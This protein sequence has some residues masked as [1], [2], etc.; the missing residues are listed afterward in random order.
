MGL[1]RDLSGIVFG[2][3]FIVEKKISADIYRPGGKQFAAEVQAKFRIP[4][5]AQLSLNDLFIKAVI[6]PEFRDSIAVR[7]IVCLCAQICFLK[8]RMRGFGKPDPFFSQ[9]HALKTTFPQWDFADYS[10]A[11]SR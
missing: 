11:F 10:I 8:F 3:G 6:A 9:L 1:N 2:A 5:K 7:A 4:G